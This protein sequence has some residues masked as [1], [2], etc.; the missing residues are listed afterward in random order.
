LKDRLFIGET[1]AVLRVSSDL[2]PMRRKQMLT[3]NRN[4]FLP[5]FFLLAIEVLI[6]VFVHDAFVRPYIGDLLVVILLYCIARSFLKIPAWIA[7]SAVLLFSYT[8]ELLQYFNFVERLG[9]A[10]SKIAVIILG[11]SF[12]WPDLLAYTIG[13]AVV[14]LI[15][16]MK[17][18]RN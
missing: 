7:A 5:A 15:E 17:G 2:Y 12:G 18:D 6:A 1:L 16:A 3:F 13:I 14:L 4:Y 8:V 9:W 11:N 10:H